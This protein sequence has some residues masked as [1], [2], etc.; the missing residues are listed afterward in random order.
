MYRATN[1]ECFHIFLDQFE[2]LETLYYDLHNRIHRISRP[3]KLIFA[4]GEYEIQLAWVTT[5]YELFVTFE[6][7]VDKK[8]FLIAQVNK[9]LKWIKKEEG[10]LF[11]T[12]THIF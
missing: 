2:R 8:A 12:G 4:L 11:L 10:K 7:L 6:P 3:L 1:V 5:N 9:L